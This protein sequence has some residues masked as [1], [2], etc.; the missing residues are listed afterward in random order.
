MIGMQNFSG[1]LPK[2]TAEKLQYFMN[3][4]VYVKCASRCV[5]KAEIHI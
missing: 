4:S 5:R 1:S 2:T 3:G